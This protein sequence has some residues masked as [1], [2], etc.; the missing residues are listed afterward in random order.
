MI[1]ELTNFIVAKGY[2]TSSVTI[3]GID[4]ERDILFL[5]LK[6]GFVGEVYLNG[7]NNTTRLDFWYAFKKGR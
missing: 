2:S 4:Q 5:D 1:K 3:D 6:Y 7:D